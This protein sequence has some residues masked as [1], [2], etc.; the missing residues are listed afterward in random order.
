MT[1]PK[2][3]AEAVD[4]L[5]RAIRAVWEPV[6]VRLA[7]QVD[8]VAR[9]C[10]RHSFTT[11]RRASMT[12]REMIEKRVEQKGYAIQEWRETEDG[13]TAILGRYVVV[14][15]DEEDYGIYLND[16]GELA[17]VVVGSDEYRNRRVQFHFTADGF[18]SPNEVHDLSA[19][20]RVEV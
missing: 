7:I 19:L 14:S 15:E 1:E 4:D 13:D 8:N 3:F 16:E 9:R 20:E 18:D 2:S 17:A 6:F 12:N 10:Y 11:E 5:G